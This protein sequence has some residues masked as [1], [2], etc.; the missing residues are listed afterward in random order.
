MMSKGNSGAGKWKKR[1]KRSLLLL[2]VPFVSALIIGALYGDATGIG[3]LL[4][5]GGLALGK[6]RVSHT[7]D[8][9]AVRV[10]DEIHVRIANEHGAGAVKAVS[11]GALVSNIRRSW[12]LFYDGIWAPT[13]ERFVGKWAV[14]LNRESSDPEQ[15]R[16]LDASE[17]GLNALLA[18]MG[19]AARADS[20]HTPDLAVAVSWDGGEAEY[21]SHGARPSG[22]IH[23]AVVLL[24]AGAGVFELVKA[25]RQ[26]RSER[27]RLP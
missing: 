1:L 8:Y 22:Y 2:A 20:P 12:W 26:R 14:R 19:E 17:H 3:R 5:R 18:K 16:K 25:L 9:V 6:A 23:N 21:G 4:S 11:A 15:A 13:S 10:G 27:P 24:C 7:S